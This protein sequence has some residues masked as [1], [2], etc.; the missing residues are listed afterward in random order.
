M[1]HIL[2]ILSTD[3]TCLILH[4]TQLCLC[5]SLSV[6][7]SLTHS[8]SFSHTHTHKHTHTDIH[9]HTFTFIFYFVSGHINYKLKQTSKKAKNHNSATS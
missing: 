7:Y 1:A 4:F 8:F 3:E 6:T 5:L 9:K 2:K